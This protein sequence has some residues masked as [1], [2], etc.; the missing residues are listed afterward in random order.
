MPS[1]IT[2]DDSILIASGT[3]MHALAREIVPQNTT[4]VIAAAI[5]VY[6]TF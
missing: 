4:S 3:T 5:N 6:K 2:A 1:L